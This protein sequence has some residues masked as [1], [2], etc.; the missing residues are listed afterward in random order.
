M[1]LTSL[2]ISFNSLTNHNITPNNIYQKSWKYSFFKE[3]EDKINEQKEEDWGF[4]SLNKSINEHNLLAKN[5]SPLKNSYL[6]QSFPSVLAPKDTAYWNGNF[7]FYSDGRAN[8]SIFSLIEPSFDKFF[9]IWRDQNTNPSTDTTFSM[10]V[11]PNSDK[12][13]GS[14]SDQCNKQTCT[15]NNLKQL[16]ITNINFAC[17]NHKS[18]KLPS[19]EKNTL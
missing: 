6:S 13:Y 11:D 4:F 14:F 19:N 12:L 5:H 3:Y 1:E 10:I 17:P 15:I 18:T 8:N 16:F 7:C 2:N 9:D